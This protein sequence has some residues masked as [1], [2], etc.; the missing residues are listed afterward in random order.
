MEKLQEF[1]K[2]SD[3]FYLLI[4]VGAALVVITCLVVTLIC[5]RR[6][7]RG[8]SRKRSK[9]ISPAKK[10]SPGSYPK[11][12]KHKRKQKPMKTAGN[13]K[14][15]HSNRITGQNSTKSDWKENMRKRENSKR[16]FVNKFQ[17]SKVPEA[18]P[19]EP[20]QDIPSALPS[21]FSD[22]GED[23]EV[24]DLNSPVRVTASRVKFFELVNC[25]IHKLH[26]YSYFTH[27]SLQ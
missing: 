13:F 5:F 7:K 20:V 3:N 1:M 8:K 14:S 26:F 6:K 27:F 25:P 15:P 16:R 11:G 10:F 23:N 24:M 4:A 9:T 21:A 22:T 2:K 17:D 19:E 18:P 12:P